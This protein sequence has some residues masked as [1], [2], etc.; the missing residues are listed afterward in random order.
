MIPDVDQSGWWTRE[1]SLERAIHGRESERVRHVLPG[2]HRV[3][4]SARRLHGSACQENASRNCTQ[5]VETSISHPVRAPVTCG[6]AMGAK[7]VHAEDCV[8]LCGSTD[9]SQ[10][11]FADTVR[12]SCVPSSCYPRDEGASEI[13]VDEGGEASWGPLIR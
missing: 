13:L 5:S 12:S 7:G 11:V 1:H 3:L 4:W 9:C 8:Q 2:L 10:P 6:C